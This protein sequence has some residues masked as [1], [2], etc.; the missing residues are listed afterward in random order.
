[1]V[2][3]GVRAQTQLFGDLSGRAAVLEQAQDLRLSRSQ[4]R[5]DGHRRAVRDV[6]GLAEDTDHPAAA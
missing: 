6:H 4:S 1:V 5:V 3:N 2:P